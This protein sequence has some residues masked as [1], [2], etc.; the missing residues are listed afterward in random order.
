[1]QCTNYFTQ[2]THKRIEKGKKREV[3]D[4]VLELESSFFSF[5]L[6]KAKPVFKFMWERDADLTNWMI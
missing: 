3:P 5:S 6:A 1:M 2:Y 4:L